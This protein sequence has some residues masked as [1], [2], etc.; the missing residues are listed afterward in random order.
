MSSVKRGW[1]ILR[2]LFSS[3]FHLARDVNITY[4][5]RQIFKT[6]ET[7]ASCK[8]E[9]LLRNGSF[10]DLSILQKREAKRSEG[11]L[12]VRRVLGEKCIP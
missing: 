10:R 9:K 4:F 3:G 2:P 6:L 5:W 7:C 1:I 12:N 11:I 8:F